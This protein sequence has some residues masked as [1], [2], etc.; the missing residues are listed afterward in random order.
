MKRFETALEPGSHSLTH[1]GQPILQSRPLVQVADGEMVNFRCYGTMMWP[2]Y[3]VSI[4]KPD[5][6]I[7]RKH[8]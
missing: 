5:L 8:E 7:S 1:P 3:V 2:R 4:V 6:A